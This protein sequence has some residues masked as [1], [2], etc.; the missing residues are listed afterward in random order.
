MIM[1][2]VRCRASRSIRRKED[3]YGFATVRNSNHHQECLLLLLLEVG[4]RYTLGNAT[5]LE[6]AISRGDGVWKAPPLPTF[7]PERD[8]RPRPSW[9]YTS[10]RYGQYVLFPHWVP[11]LV[12]A[13]FAAAIGIRMPYQFSLRTLL[14][15]TTIVAAILGLMVAFGSIRSCQTSL[16][17]ILTTDGAY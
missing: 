14:I 2:T 7:A 5:R 11:A 3:W 1:R 4:F 8:N 10:D 6:L 12:F 17:F 15:L 13:V 16:D 9:V